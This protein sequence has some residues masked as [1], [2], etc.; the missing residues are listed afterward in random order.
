MS[1]RRNKAFEAMGIATHGFNALQNPRKSISASMLTLNY[2]NGLATAAFSPVCDWLR[3]EAKDF[4]T[5]EMVAER[6]VAIIRYRLISGEPAYTVVNYTT[7]GETDKYNN[8]TRIRT[9]TPRPNKVFNNRLINAPNF[10]RCDNYMY[11]I[12]LQAHFR[13]ISKRIGELTRAYDNNINYHKLQKLNVVPS[14]M[15]ATMKA[16]LQMQADAADPS[17]MVVGSNDALGLMQRVNAIDLSA[18]MKLE[19]L[20]TEIDATLNSALAYVGIHSSSEST[21]TYQNTANVY[22]DVN[23]AKNN[24]RFMALWRQRIAM[25]CVEKWGVSMR[26]KPNFENFSEEG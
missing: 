5:R 19:A 12:G 22:R 3:M 16:A 15:E 26:F 17:D 9:Q 2:L 8:P 14:G 18:E 6:N 24:Y 13:V 23:R 7:D 11:P 21:E 25:E 1:K 10:V 20:R 4:L